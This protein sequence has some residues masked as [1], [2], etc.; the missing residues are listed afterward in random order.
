MEGMNLDPYK[1][2]CGCAVKI[3][4]GE[5]VYPALDH[6]KRELRGTGICFGEREDADIFPSRGEPKILR[7]VTSFDK[8][9]FS[10]V[11]DFNPQRAISLTSVHR[12][13][14]HQDLA[15]RW[16]K[17]YRKLSSRE[18]AVTVGKGHTIEAYSKEDEFLLFDFLS[19]TRGKSEGFW[20][21]NNDTIQLIDPTLP[22]GAKEQVFTSL[23]N[24]LNDLFALGAVDR[25]QIQPVYAGPDEETVDQI[26][27]NIKDYCSRYR[28]Q[29]LD[30]KPLP[31]RSPLLGATV[32]GKTEKHPPT[33]YDQLK[34]GDQILVH[35]PFGDLVPIN[36][37]LGGLMMGR[38]QLQ[39]WGFEL[40]EVREAKQERL[41]VLASSNLEV[42][43]IINEFCPKT[44]GNFDPHRHIKA[45]GDLSGPGIG[46]FQ[47]IAE[48][49]E[50]DIR[51][52]KIPLEHE[53]MAK[54]ASRNQ[55][56]PDA[57]TGTNGAIAILA[58]PDVIENVKYKLEKL[59]EKPFI[60][61]EVERTRENKTDN[62]GRL[63]LP[64]EAEEVVSTGSQN[65]YEIV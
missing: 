15:D 57:T 27:R 60:I 62:G 45:T 21:A 34:R 14:G 52:R 1:L 56:L 32:V 23:N 7:E 9:D 48:R 22:L 5:V 12:P 10:Q 2:A 4:L 61:G 51:L 36:L 18:I 55:L 47:E 38:D 39:E 20:V 65:S 13:S 19:P 6:L 42:G 11:E 33:F 17:V 46:V 54:V 41:K 30:E 31:Y 43:K 50:V 53:K 8:V 24:A 40:E 44:G 49:S 64:P 28:F 26:E 25:I 37:Y 35:R 58:S 63:F 59:N 3:D 16:L 29:L